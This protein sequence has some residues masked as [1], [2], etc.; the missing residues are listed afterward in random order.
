MPQ[1]LIAPF[2]YAAK[3]RFASGCILSGDQPDP[4]RE[5]PTRREMSPAIEGGNQGGGDHRLDAGKG[6][7]SFEAIIGC[8][9][10]DQLSINLGNAFVRGFQLSNECVEVLLRQGL[11]FSFS[12]GNP[13]IFA[14]PDGADRNDDAIFPKKATNV[15]NQPSAFRDDPVACSVQHLQILLLRRLHRHKPHGWTQCSLVDRLFIDRIILRAFDEWHNE[16]WVNEA[17]RK[18]IAPKQRPQ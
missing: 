8:A 15:I 14:E 3:P 5:S 18:P 11:Q 1:V 2:A 17:N 4:C 9:D 16:A 13:D 10:C 7:Q 6:R 12:N